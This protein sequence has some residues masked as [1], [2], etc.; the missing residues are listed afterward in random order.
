MSSEATRLARIQEVVSERESRERNYVE[1]VTSYFEL[2]NDVY[3]SGWG[4]SHHFPP[5]SDGQSLAEAQRTAQCRLAD[6]AGL[7]PGTRALDIGSGVGGPALTIAAHSGAHVTGLDLTPVRSECARTRAAEQGL[8][9]QTDFVEG[10]A[11]DMPFPDGS[12][13]AV[14][15]FDSIVHMPEKERVHR[16]AARVLKP[17]GVYLGYDWLAADGLGDEETSRFIEPICRHHCLTHLST[18]QT[19]AGHLRD[20]GLDP[21]RVA[22]ASEQGSLEPVWLMLDEAADLLDDSDDVTPLLRFMQRGIR[23]LSAA[24]REGAFLVGYWEARKPA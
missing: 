10:D 15:S 6:R 12:F 18:P 8:T 21:V 17:G 14:Y 9:A 13:D 4:E 20:A 19:L 1:M 22:D 3:R 16:E 2:V 23:V 5:F 24:A 7:R 11:L